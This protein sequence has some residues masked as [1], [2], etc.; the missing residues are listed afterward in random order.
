MDT[1][2]YLIL[3]EFSGILMS[4]ES[5]KFLKYRLDISGNLSGF[6]RFQFKIKVVYYKAFLF[7]TEGSK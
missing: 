3:I 6:P 2:G 1:S 5:S 4:V 7:A